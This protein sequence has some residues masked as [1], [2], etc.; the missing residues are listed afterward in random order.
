MIMRAHA[1]VLKHA[2]PTGAQVRQA[3]EPHLC[4][5]GTHTRILKAIRRATSEPHR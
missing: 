3:L 2:H 4:R 5:C 1:L